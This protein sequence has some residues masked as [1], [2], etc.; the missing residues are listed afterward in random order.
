MERARG[1]QGTRGRI[2]IEKREVGSDERVQPRGFN[3]E[4]SNK[5]ELLR[6]ERRSMYIVRPY[7]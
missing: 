4:G 1:G 5:G 3:R 6:E 7:I 2:F